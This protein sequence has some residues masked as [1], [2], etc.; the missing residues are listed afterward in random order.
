MMTT[1]FIFYEKSYSNEHLT[2][3]SFIFQVVQLSPKVLFP[4]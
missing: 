4:T 1:I 3:K 2:V